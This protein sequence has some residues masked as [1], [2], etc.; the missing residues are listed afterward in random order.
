[1]PA[2]APPRHPGAAHA[3]IDLVQRRSRLAAFHLLEV[4][5]ADLKARL[6]R[7]PVRPS[8]RYRDLV[9]VTQL[10]RLELQHLD[11]QTT[12]SSDGGEGAANTDSPGGPGDEGELYAW[13]YPWGLT[14]RVRLRAD[15]HRYSAR[16][17]RLGRWL[18]PRGRARATLA[19]ERRYRA[20]ALRIPWRAPAT[21]PRASA[22]G[23]TRADDAVGAPPAPARVRGAPHAAA[24]VAG[25]LGIL[26]LVLLLDAP[27]PPSLDGNGGPTRHAGLPEPWARVPGLAVEPQPQRDDARRAGRDRQ[28][29]APDDL[30]GNRGAQPPEGEGQAP[31]VGAEAIPPSAP[32]PAL[33]A[34]EP[35]PPPA[36]PAAPPPPD[37]SPPAAAN[38]PEF[39]FEH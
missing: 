25:A 8:R 1:M 39:G 23:A 36:A 4:A 31:P 35:T 37:A 19:A 18:T 17:E 32:A 2:T 34:S 6:R 11:G 13:S 15:L 5:E 30:N 20:I 27:G 12:C 22:E 3:E 14:A 9:L 24:A 7:R 21:R 10:I 28:P 29:A 33:T 26:A 38:P 16:R